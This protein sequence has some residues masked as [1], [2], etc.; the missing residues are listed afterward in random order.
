MPEERHQMPFP[1]NKAAISLVNYEAMQDRAYDFVYKRDVRRDERRALMWS[2]ASAR[3]YQEWP[4]AGKLVDMVRAAND[5]AAPKALKDIRR[6]ID[7]KMI[8]TEQDGVHRYYFLPPGDKLNRL[9]NLLAKIREVVA[10]QLA[11]PDDPI[12]G[13]EVFDEVEQDKVY[14]NVI[15][16]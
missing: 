10:I 2:V 11:N 4:K 5:C 7:H 1:S 3:K 12:A 16:K 6:A 15:A 13:I 8:E 9:I 14:Y